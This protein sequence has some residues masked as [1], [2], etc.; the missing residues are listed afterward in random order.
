MKVGDRGRTPVSSVE[1]TE[2]VDS[3]HPI[4]PNLKQLLA[5]FL[6]GPPLSVTGYTIKIV[7]YQE[8]VKK[9]VQGKCFLT[10][11]VD[12]EVSYN[13][14]DVFMYCTLDQ[15]IVIKKTPSK[16]VN[17]VKMARTQIFTL[18]FSLLLMSYQENINWVHYILISVQQQ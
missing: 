11:A 16:P 8:N 4:Q 18:N 6:L 5:T 3:N 10:N 9:K 14:H 1:I 2:F 15:V 7:A 17:H 13:N 12:V